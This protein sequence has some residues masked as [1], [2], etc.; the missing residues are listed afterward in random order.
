VIQAI[1]RAGRAGK[2]KLTDASVDWNTKESL[3]FGGSGGIPLCF[4]NNAKIEM[5]QAILTK[6][7]MTIVEGPTSAFVKL[8]DKLPLGADIN[9]LPGGGF[10]CNKAE[11][12][13]VTG[14]YIHA[15]STKGDIS[16]YKNG[17]VSHDIDSAT[18]TIMCMR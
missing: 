11:G 13:V 2:N 1:P 3:A 4:G 5:A 8:K 12:W 18:L 15:V 9:P 17:C 7:V 16:P 6:D 14:C 10:E